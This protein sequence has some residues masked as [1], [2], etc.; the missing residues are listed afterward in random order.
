ME[1]IRARDRETLERIYADD[2]TH[3]HAVGRVDDKMQRIAALISGE[4]TIEAAEADDVS[5]RTYG[6]TT[7]VVTGQSTIT[8][9]GENQ[10]PT[11]YRWIAV[12]VR[13]ANRWQLVASQA[14]RI[15]Q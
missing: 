3:T 5:I 2:Y 9:Q 12:Y 7:A 15:A 14:T 11:R 1:A 10:S 13:R 6:T 8:S 4:L